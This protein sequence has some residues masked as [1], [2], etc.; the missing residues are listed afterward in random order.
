MKKAVVYIK[1]L[2]KS[3]VNNDFFGMASEMSYMSCLGIFPMMLFLTGVFGWAGKHDF[4]IPVFRFMSSIMPG[5]SMGLVQTVLHEAIFYSMGGF[6][7]LLGFIIALFLTTNTLAIISKGLNRA[8]KINETRSFLHTRLLAFLMVCVN[9]AVLFLAI[10]LIIF[11]KISLGFAV[12]YL[13]LGQDVASLWLFL[14]WPVAFLALYV[15]AFLQYYILPDLKGSE[16]LKLKSTVPGTFFFCT[17]WL[18]GSWGFSIYV[19]NLHTYNFIYGTI[20]AFAVLMVWMYYSSLLILIGA[21]INS[22][23][24]NRL[25]ISV[26]K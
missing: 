8:Y 10:N 7:G 23:V 3:V 11:G 19:N 24:Y 25:E 5:D 17:C 4:M 22:Q 18:F 16:W 9:T 13:N 15:M 21:E 26:G 1:R 6:W 14:R 20:G 12:K 2:T